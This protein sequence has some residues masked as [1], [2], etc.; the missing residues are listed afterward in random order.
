MEL[1]ESSLPLQGIYAQNLTIPIR[2]ESFLQLKQGTGG[3]T[4]SVGTVS[5]YPAHTI[6][7]L[8]SACTVALYGDR[9]RR[10]GMEG[11]LPYSKCE[12]FLGYKTLSR[13][14]RRSVCL[15]PPR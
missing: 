11:N 6:P 4:D 9:G 13:E 5:A 2:V 8:Y 15:L 14:G 12:V 10:I 1:Q 3:V 7:I